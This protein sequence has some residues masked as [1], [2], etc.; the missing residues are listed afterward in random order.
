MAIIIPGGGVASISG[1]LGGVTFSRNKGGAYVRNRTVPTNPGTIFQGA[2]RSILADL[3]SRWNDNLTALQREGWDTY[4]AN[5]LLPN[6]LGFPRDVGGLA[7]YVRSNVSRV[8]ALEPRVDDA[9]IV[10]NLGAFTDPSISAATASATTI[11]VAF[12]N[13]D[14]WA[15]EDDSVLLV[16]GSRPK[17]ETQ[18][19]FKGPYR[20]AEGIFGSSTSPPVSPLS[21]AMPFAFSIGQRV[22]AKFS[23][24]RADGRLSNPVRDFET[25]T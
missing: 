12:D 21:V 13:T 2:V 7:M 15:N 11:D 25:G 23:I 5:V 1:S 8:Q 17:N 19:F 14:E 16:Y 18:N 4:A 6:S 20:F 9:P 10:F 24:T 22:F 3:T